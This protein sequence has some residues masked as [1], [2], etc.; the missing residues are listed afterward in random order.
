MNDELQQKL[1]QIFSAVFS[2]SGE[3]AATEMNQDNTSS[4]DSITH[5]SLIAAIESEFGVFVET[6]DALEFTSFSKIA[7]FLQSEGV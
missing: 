6:S 1:S 7:A 3:V 5:V 4:W 2:P